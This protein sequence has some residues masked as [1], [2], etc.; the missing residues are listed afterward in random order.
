MVVNKGKQSLSINKNDLQQEGGNSTTLSGCSPPP[1]DFHAL[2]C[3]FVRGTV[4][5]HPCLTQQPPV[6]Q[7]MEPLNKAGVASWDGRIRLL[8][9]MTSLVAWQP[10]GLAQAQGQRITAG[11]HPLSHTHSTQ[12]GALPRQTYARPP[13]RP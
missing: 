3:I 8:T 7:T 5:P 1:R 13:A 6:F 2:T 9:G 10:L 12:R 11:W 4:Y